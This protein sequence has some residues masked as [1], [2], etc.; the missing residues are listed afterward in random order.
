MADCSG[1]AAVGRALGHAVEAAAGDLVGLAAEEFPGEAVVGGA[2][3]EVDFGGPVTAV[4][5]RGRVDLDVSVTSVSRIWPVGSTSM[6][7]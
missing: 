3:D 6:L 7:P 2:M 4:A 5:G 1:S